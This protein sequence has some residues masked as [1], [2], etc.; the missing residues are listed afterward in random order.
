MQV[1]RIGMDIAKQIFDLHGVDR[2]GRVV[3]RQRLKA[4]AGARIF[5]PAQAQRGWHG[6][7]RRGAL[8]ELPRF[9]GQYW[10]CG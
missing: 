4:G 3:L 2:R 8:L 1:T 7:L 9:G 10:A 6:S 5:C